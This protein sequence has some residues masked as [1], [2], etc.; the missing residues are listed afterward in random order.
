MPTGS[1]LTAPTVQVDRLVG[2]LQ[3]LDVDEAIDAVGHTA[4][5]GDHQCVTVVTPSAPMTTQ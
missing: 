1:A 3:P 4:V 2:E 5:V